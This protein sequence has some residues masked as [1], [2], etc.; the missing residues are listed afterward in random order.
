MTIA[1]NQ[2]LEVRNLLSFRKTLTAMELNDTSQRLLNYIESAGAQKIGGGI[3]ATYAIEGDKLDIAM[4]IP[5]DKEVP[6]TEEFEFKPLLRLE[7]CIMATH[8]GNPNMLENTLQGLNDYIVQNGLNP[9]SAGFIVP[10]R[11]IIDIYDAENFEVNV[12]ISI[13]PNVV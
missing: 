5:I 6:S 2:T 11:E 10:K 8:K 13:D 9:I 1:T 12:Y 3:S 7:N 4:Y